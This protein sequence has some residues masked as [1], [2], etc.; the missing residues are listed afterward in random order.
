MLSFS[1]DSGEARESALKCDVVKKG[2]FVTR[3][4]T[5]NLQELRNFSLVKLKSILKSCHR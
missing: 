2:L 4:D 3:S 1:G 5:N